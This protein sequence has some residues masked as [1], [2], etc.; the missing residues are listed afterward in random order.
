[1]LLENVAVRDQSKPER[2]RSDTQEST[3]SLTHTSAVV[4][5]TV[6]ARH[7]KSQYSYTL[8]SVRAHQLPSRTYGGKTSIPKAIV[9]ATTTGK[10]RHCYL[11]PD[12]N[13]QKGVT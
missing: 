8:L 12:L 13:T 9:C 1:M 7:G 10:E 5:P 4:A 11:C 6:R 2:V 3:K